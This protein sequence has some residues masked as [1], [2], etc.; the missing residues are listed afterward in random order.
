MRHENPSRSVSKLVSA[1]IPL[2]TLGAPAKGSKGSF[3]REQSVC[4]PREESK[5]GSETTNGPAAPLSS[6]CPLVFV[7][8]WRRLCLPGCLLSVTAAAETGSVCA[9]PPAASVQKPSSRCWAIA[10][11]FCFT[12]VAMLLFQEMLDPLGHRAPRARCPRPPEGEPGLLS[13]CRSKI[14][15]QKTCWEEFWSPCLRQRPESLWC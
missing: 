5:E 3:W 7:T 4:Q 9:N 11:R 14:E 13:K 10:Q 6:S 1:S 2:H 12:P 15:R 8:D